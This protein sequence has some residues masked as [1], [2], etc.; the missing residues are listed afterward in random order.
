[1]AASNLSRSFSFSL[2][3]PKMV[4]NQVPI[5]S[6]SKTDYSNGGK[7][8]ILIKVARVFRLNQGWLYFYQGML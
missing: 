3:C 6:N 2:N 8:I 7:K 1:M 5:T 4:V